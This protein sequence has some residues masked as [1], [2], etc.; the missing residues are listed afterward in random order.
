MIVVVILEYL[1]KALRTVILL[2][3]RML[4]LQATILGSL[5]K[6]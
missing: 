3:H 6:S 2:L 4:F 1:E 5:L